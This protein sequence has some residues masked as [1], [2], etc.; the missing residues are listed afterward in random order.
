MP[1]SLPV[2]FV[3]LWA[4]ENK[5]KFNKDTAKGGHTPEE[6]CFLWLRNFVSGVGKSCLLLRFSDNSFTP[7]FLTTIG[8]DYKV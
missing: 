2:D 3:R 5:K 4:H 6:I 7:S 1:A 8:I